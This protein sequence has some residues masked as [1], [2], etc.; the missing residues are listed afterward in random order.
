MPLK[1]T[2][3]FVGVNLILII[4]FGDTFDMLVKRPSETIK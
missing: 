3:I 4:L 2:I 1:I